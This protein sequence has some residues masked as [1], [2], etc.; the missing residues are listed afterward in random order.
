M[1]IFHLMPD[2]LHMVT[3]TYMFLLILINSHCAT[4]NRHSLLWGKEFAVNSST[5]LYY[6]S[7][8]TAER[9]TAE[10]RAS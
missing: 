3:P 9:R 2:I 8:K 5:I 1:Y 4:I 6:H 10:V 7:L